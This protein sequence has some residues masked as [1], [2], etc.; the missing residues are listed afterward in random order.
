MILLSGI[1]TFN[2]TSLELKHFPAM[3]N[4]TPELAFNRTSLELKLILRDDR[5]DQVGS[6]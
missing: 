1:S 4:F 2:R 5:F 6:F 3:Q